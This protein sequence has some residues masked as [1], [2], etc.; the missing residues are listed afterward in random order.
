MTNSCGS[1]LTI[2]ALNGDDLDD[3]AFTL[4]GVFE[5]PVFM[6]CQPSKPCCLATISCASLS[7]KLA[8]RISE[9]GI[10]TKRGKCPRICAAT[11]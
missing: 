8:A 2:V 9:S 5:S 1:A 7:L 6:A 11:G 4:S 10:F 3:N